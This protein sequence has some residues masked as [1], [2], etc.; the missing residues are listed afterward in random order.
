MSGKD[1]DVE[2]KSFGASQP[3]CWPSVNTLLRRLTSEVR[4][5][6]HPTGLYLYGSLTTGDFDPKNSDVDLMAATVSE[7][8]DQQFERLQL[9]HTDVVRD[10]P[11]WFD[12]IEVAY[13]SLET[14]R[15]LRC[16]RQ[17]SDPSDEV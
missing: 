11:E 8:S 12:R 7:V 6:L 16:F 2:D 13:V 14:L 1:N 17:L 4:R 9:M 10:N 5:I 15:T 3:T